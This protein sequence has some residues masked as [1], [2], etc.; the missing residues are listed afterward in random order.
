MENKGSRMPRAR[1]SEGP[2]VLTAASGAAKELG[3]DGSGLKGSWRVLASIPCDKNL[4]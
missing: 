4:L 2:S 3:G 1:L